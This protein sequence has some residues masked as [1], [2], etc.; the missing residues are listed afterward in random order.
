MLH[1]N[2]RTIAKFTAFNFR[3]MELRGCLQGKEEA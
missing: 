3:K 1:W 2:V